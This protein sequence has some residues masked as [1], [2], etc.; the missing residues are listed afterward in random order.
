MNE[1][2]I[3][4]VFKD[5]APLRIDRID[6]QGVVL[7]GE[8]DSWPRGFTFE[9]D[10]VSDATNYRIRRV[11][12][13]NGWDS[14]RLG[15]GADQGG[16]VFAGA[17]GDPRAL[18]PGLY[19]FRLAISGLDIPNRRFDFEI[20]E[21]RTTSLTLDVSLDPRQVRLANGGNLATYDAQIVRLLSAPDSRIDGQ[22]ASDWLQSPVL[23]QNRKACLLDLLAK[24]R[25]AP[26]ATDPL[27][28]AVESIFFCATERIYVKVQPAFYERLHELV[29]NPQQPFYLEGKPT[30][31]DH[32]RLLDEIAAKGLEPTTAGYR[33][34]SF[35]QEGRDC[36]QAVVA[37]PPVPNGQYYADLDIDL[38]NPLQDLE[39]FCIHMGELCGPDGETDHLA[40][41]D[42]LARR[43]TGPFLYYD[44]IEAAPAP[45]P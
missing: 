8:P 17:N 36:M 31:P 9:F 12:T 29:E 41:H 45:T 40:L 6:S 25:T 33:L 10:G 5:G 16:L 14:F 20:H 27:I 11:C 39:G 2:F 34:V 30:S 1:R 7:G 43:E 21:N 18:P 26:T 38:G 42:A 32:Q 44:V 13:L 4:Q 37:V 3:V 35:R 22:P 15:V 28:T 23:R 24:L 19:W